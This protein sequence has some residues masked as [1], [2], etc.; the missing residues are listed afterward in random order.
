MDA[1]EDELEYE[2]E[3]EG[4]V[5]NP[6]ALPVAARTP[7]AKFV[8]VFVCIIVVVHVLAPRTPYA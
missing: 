4:R 2:D 6:R 5:P 8:V 3:D 7:T 1:N